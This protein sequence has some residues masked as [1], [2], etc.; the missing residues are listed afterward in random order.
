[1]AGFPTSNIIGKPMTEMGRA[2]PRPR[3]VVLEMNALKMAGIVPPRDWK[4]ALGEYLKSQTERS[5]T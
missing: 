1:L 4:A 3:Y 2:G 5:H